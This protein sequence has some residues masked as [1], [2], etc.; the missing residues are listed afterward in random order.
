M[1]GSYLATTGL[2]LQPKSNNMVGTMVS[3]RVQPVH[4]WHLDAIVKTKDKVV[5]LTAL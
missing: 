1:S 4:P 2:S 5:T 3:S